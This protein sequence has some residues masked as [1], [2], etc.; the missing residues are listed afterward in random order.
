MDGTPPDP[1]LY[2]QAQL[3]VC[4]KGCP[5][6]RARER[7]GKGLARRLWQ[8]KGT[9]HRAWYERRTGEPG[10]AWAAMSLAHD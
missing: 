2:Y 4:G 9:D 6:G 8:R 5:D 10:D 3:V 7:R 1:P